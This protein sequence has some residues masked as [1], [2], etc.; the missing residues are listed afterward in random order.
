MPINRVLPEKDNSSEGYEEPFNRNADAVDVRGTYL[1]NDSSNDSTALITRDASNN[2]TFTDSILGV[3]KTLSQLATASSGVSQNDFLLDNEPV[4]V[5]I[6]YTPTYT[7]IKVTNETWK[8][9]AGL[10]LVKNIDYTYTGN[11]V[12]TEVRKVYDSL[13]LTV[14]AQVTWTYTYTGNTLT[15]A[16]ETRDV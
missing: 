11:K 8:K 12:T 9:T 5:G 16:V 10:L 13:G 3:T 15:S 14:V 4:S 1:Q 7:G 6:T 2:M